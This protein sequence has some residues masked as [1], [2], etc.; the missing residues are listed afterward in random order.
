MAECKTT[1][2][3]PPV[4]NISSDFLLALRTKI[5]IGRLLFPQPHGKVPDDLNRHS[6]CA[7]MFFHFLICKERLFALGTFE[8]FLVFHVIGVACQILSSRKNPG[9][10]ATLA[11]IFLRLKPSVVLLVL[12]LVSL[13][14]GVVVE[15]FATVLI[16]ALVIPFH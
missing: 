16:P 6:L 11:H 4:V 15:C 1:C 7:P 12:A 9:R 2:R 14:L 10:F 5:I 8:L 13:P 3:A